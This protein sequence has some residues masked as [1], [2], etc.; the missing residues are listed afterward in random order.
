MPENTVYVGRG[1]AWGNPFRVGQTHMPAVLLHEVT[2][3]RRGCFIEFS[4]AGRPGIPLVSFGEPLS[5]RRV[6]SLY[7][8]HCIEQI[9]PARIRDELRGKDLACWCRLDEPCHADVLLDLANAP[10][11]EA[12]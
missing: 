10:T 1:S 6:I 12:A 2:A 9:G 4:V 8:G 5:L 3:V 7:R 11:C